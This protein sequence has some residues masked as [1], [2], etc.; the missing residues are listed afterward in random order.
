METFIKVISIHQAYA[1]PKDIQTLLGFG[2]SKTTN[3]LKE[4]RMFVDER[5]SYFKPHTPF[6]DVPGEAIRYNVLCIRHFDEYRSVLTAGGRG[7]SFKEDLPRLKE[8]WE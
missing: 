5:P 6:I 8:A 2:R 7:Y 4:F 3:F 1:Y